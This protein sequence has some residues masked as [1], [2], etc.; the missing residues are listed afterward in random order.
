MLYAPCTKVDTKV[1][2]FWQW[3]NDILLCFSSC[4]IFQSTF[5]HRNIQQ[6]TVICLLVNAK[7]FTYEN[8]RFQYQHDFYYKCS[9]VSLVAP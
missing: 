1:L 5:K 3:D 6:V 7:Y 2:H 8:D 9:H 4:N